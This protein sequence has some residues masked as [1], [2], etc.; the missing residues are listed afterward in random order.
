MVEVPDGM[1]YGAMRSGNRLGHLWEP[2]PN[3][4]GMV[5][6]VCRR[7]MPRPVRL[8]DVGGS[9]EPCPMCLALTSK[10]SE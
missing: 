5:R 3:L 1:V 7:F 6:P 9:L 10:E 2:W 8:L 4:D